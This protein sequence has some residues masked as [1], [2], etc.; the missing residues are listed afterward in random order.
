MSEKKLFND[1]DV[2]E[3][4]N[5]AIALQHEV[6]NLYEEYERLKELTREMYEALEWL[7]NLRSGRA[8]GGD[9]FSAND[10]WED[11]WDSAIKAIEK[12]RG[13]QCHTE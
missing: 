11:A 13:E 7:L 12:A 1:D 6:K 4:A 5:I 10:Q 2:L 9:D 3:C 8:K